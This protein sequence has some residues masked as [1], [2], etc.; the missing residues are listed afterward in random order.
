MNLLELSEA[1]KQA[2]V[3]ATERADRARDSLSRLKSSA[4]AAAT[5]WRI[6]SAG[7]IA[8]FLMGRRDPT[9]GPSVGG[10]LFGTIAQSVI[11]ALGA[12]ATAGAAASSAADAAAAATVN[13]TV[14]P[15]A[16]NA[17]VTPDEVASALIQG[18]SAQV[19]PARA[20]AEGTAQ[21]EPGSRASIPSPPVG[22]DRPHVAEMADLEDRD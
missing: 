3:Q 14:P 9:A 8:G 2:E 11:T 20:T 5:P 18:K 17:S 7:A 22:L 13:A 6:V 15:F 12:S 4:K 16:S 21:A 19:K 10:R 1:V